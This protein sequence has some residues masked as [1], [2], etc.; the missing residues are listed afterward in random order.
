MDQLR[1]YEIL[2]LQPGC[3]AEDVKKAYAELS[4][5]FHPEEHPEEFQQIHEAYATLVRGNRR[6]R[7]AGKGETKA[8]KEVKEAKPEDHFQRRL[9][10]S[11]QG[12]EPFEEEEKITPTYDFECAVDRAEQEETQRLHQTAVQA[13]NEFQILLRPEYKEKLKLLKAFFAKEE[14]ADVLK[15]PEFMEGLA[16]ILADS[17]LKLKKRNYDYIIDFYRLRGYEERQLIPEAAALYRVLD[18]KR[19][20]N[21]KKKE[22]LAYVVPIGIVAGIQAGFKGAI[23]DSQALV[24]MMLFAVAAV[25]L[26]RLYRKLYE[27]HSSIFSQFVIAVILVVSQFGA[28]MIDFYGTLFGT[29]ENGN[30]FAASLMMVGLL[31]SLALVFAAL[32]LKIKQIIRK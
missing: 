4:K 16:K 17:R 3:S 7:E 9:Q 27:N 32:I 31:W 29:V 24:T 19:G 28:I 23:R 1:A 15:K 11:V 14:Y 20:M 21:A 6:G 25:L 8:V 18:Q 26:I 13:L 10:R 5:Q 22:N 2:G 12:A 30:V